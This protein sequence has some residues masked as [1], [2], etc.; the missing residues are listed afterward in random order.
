MTV[1]ERVSMTEKQLA[2]ICNRYHVRE[3]ALY[4]SVLREDFRDDSDIDV[5]VEFEPDASIGFSDLIGL[6]QDLADTV[7]REVDLVERRS[8]HPANR[9]AVLE[10]AQTIW[11]EWQALD[12][13]PAR[14][15]RREWLQ[16][17]VM[18]EAAD[19]LAEML[20][21]QNRA[22]VIGSDLRRSALIV[23]LTRIGHLAGRL[24]DDIRRRYSDVD[25]HGWEERG[26][27]LT[28]RYWDID[29]NMVWTM[30][31]DEAPRLRE[32]IARILESEFS[33]SAAS[34]HNES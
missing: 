10:Q 29:W 18:I 1:Q 15:F 3:L 32:Y 33:D 28:R 30:A 34:Q 9:D 7:G 23:P 21:G 19:D 17:H 6:Q 13:M 31:V 8:L 12:I 24:P 5:L 16:L 14:P 4:G 26:D 22:T 25:W 2:A 27:R 20:D 11:P